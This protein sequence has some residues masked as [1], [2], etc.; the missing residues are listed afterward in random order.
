VLASPSP[1]LSTSG[2]LS[3]LTWHYKPGVY[4]GAPVPTEYTNLVRF[5]LSR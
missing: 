3:I 4:D 2:L 5:K 1:L